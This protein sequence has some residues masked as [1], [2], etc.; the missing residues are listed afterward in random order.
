MSPES[1]ARRAL[2]SDLDEMTRIVTSAFL[3]D[4]VWGPSFPDPATR[5]Q[6]AGAYWRFMIEEALRFPESRVI[7]TADTGA[8]TLRAVA[9]WYPPGE[10][11]VSPEAHPAYDALVHELLGSDAAAALDHAGAQFVAARPAEP[12][13]YL[14]LLAVAPEA[15]GGG[16]GMALLRSALAEYDT[17]GIPTYL[18]SS[19]PANDA[20]Y[21]RLGYRPRQVVHLATGAAVQ[22][23][24]RDAAASD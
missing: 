10:D 15:R 16:Y 23:Y 12:H 4:P 22:T 20:R 13:A 19:N 8:D 2:A 9:V 3:D 6:I 7:D 11:E 17:A 14:T 5:P 21:E 18:E 24:W 1:T